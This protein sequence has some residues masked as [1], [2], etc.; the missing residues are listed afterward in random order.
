[1]MS[2]PDGDSTGP[3]RRHRHC[4]HYFT[5]SA[6]TTHRR[7]R[8]VTRTL[9][10]RAGFAARPTTLWPFAGAD[11]LPG[12]A[13]LAGW[14]GRVIVTLVTGYTRPGDRVL[15]LNPPTPSRRWSTFLATRGLDP[16]DG[17]TEAVWTIIRLGRGADITTAAPAPDYLFTHTDVTRR[18][19][20]ESASGP[21]LQRL[22]QHALADD[23]HESD[24][25]AA[26]AERR[27]DDRFDLIITSVHPHDTNWL[28]HTDWTT[29]LTATGT[30]AAVTHSD[31]ASSRL[32]NPMPAIV[33]TFR[34]RDWRWLDH[35]AVLT[36]PLPAP[37]NAPT[38]MSPI[39][40]PVA[41]P[42]ATS[43]VEQLPIRTAHHDLL[44]FAAPPSTGHGHTTAAGETSDA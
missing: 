27:P 33:G 15:L 5:D 37:T 25:R 41:T 7:R 3:Q 34:S 11:Q 29:V 6:R 18:H 43:R 19:A 39:A 35:I 21:R 9:N 23:H 4:G 36:E 20:V 26:R 2:T 40:V 17:L 24:R 12:T 1:M 8:A 38:A 14:L 16:Y 31:S 42:A 44:L 30:I 22:N 28:A 13:R 32:M 10:H